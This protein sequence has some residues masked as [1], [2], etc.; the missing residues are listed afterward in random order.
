MEFVT[1]KYHLKRHLKF[2][3]YEQLQYSDNPFVTRC[4]VTVSQVLLIAVK[5]T[6]STALDEPPRAAI[7]QCHISLL[8]TRVHI[9][10]RYPYT[11]S[12]AGNNFR[13]INS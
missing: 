4:P 13:Q 11:T 2:G 8:A 6:S 5:P 12:T 10:M 1:L 9:K 3:F 7:V